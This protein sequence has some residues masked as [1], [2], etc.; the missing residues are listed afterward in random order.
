VGENALYGDATANRL[1]GH[2]GDDT[3]VGRGGDDTLLGGGGSDDFLYDLG[4]GV[5]IVVEIAGES[6][7]DR[8]VFGAG[9][10]QGDVTYQFGADQSE[11]L[12]SLAGGGSI[13]LEQQFVGDAAGVDSIHFADGFSIDTLDIFDELT[14][15]APVV[16]QGIADL[17]VDEDTA[18]D[19]TVPVDAFADANVRNQLT[20][21]AQL[22]G[23]L[24]LPAWLLF[25]GLSFTGTPL[26]DDVGAFDIEVTAT[27]DFGQSVTT[28][29]SLT[30]A[31]V[32][33]SPT[34]GETL[35]ATQ[36][37]S[38]GNSFNY[39]VP[40]AAF[41]DVDAGDLLTLTATLADGSP[42]PT[43]LQFDGSQFT[44]MPDAS[45][46]GILSLVVA[47]T[48]LAGESVSQNLQINVIPGGGLTALFGNENDD[49]LTGG[50]TAEFVVGG[51][52]DDTLA[53]GGSSDIYFY[54]LGDGNDLVRNAVGRGIDDLDLLS[55][56][57]GL[58]VSDVTLAQSGDDLLVSIA[59]GGQI[60]V[61]DFYH[62]GQLAQLQWTDGTTLSYNEIVVQTIGGTTGDD[63]IVRGDGH[64]VLGG[65][66]GNDT[67]SAGTG[68]D[69]VIGGAGD[70]YLQGEWH[71]DAYVYNLGDG[72]DTIYEYSSSTSFS[73]HLGDK[74]VLGPGIAP[75]EIIVT[76]NND[77]LDDVTI[78]FQGVVGSIFLNEQ[79]AGTNYGLETIEFADGTVW[80]PSDL[81]HVGYAQAMTSGD[82]RIFG[83]QTNDSINGAEGNDSLYGRLGADV[84]T[85]GA[86]D[87]YLDGNWHGDTYVYNL[88]DGHDTIYEYSSHTIHS[89]HLG[90]KLVLGPGSRRRTSSSP[91]MPATGRT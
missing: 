59:G 32:N 55:F 10:A 67:I 68:N 44:G 5:D 76:R 70:D 36:E 2:L 84:L 20:Y 66:G 9:I 24:P 22:A 23:G 40:A 90:D 75:S 46:V 37:A 7:G 88:G 29:F 69:I 61:Q 48:D 31:N 81:A 27:D 34:V 14:N 6:A 78:T 71:G 79:Y 87:D 12:V 13:T 54:N 16:D 74:L 35:P 60:L 80:T 86:G 15:V 89:R 73:R 3:L 18:L 26:N 33:D 42:L 8:L 72:D 91:A 82:D 19:F 4:D 65:G 57:S 45:D 50:A 28:Q 43:W 77:D 64:H 63:N 83:I 53:A 51:A 1:D 39:T 47:A 30:V 56:G 38:T 25:D 58:A 52:G 85:G 62:F 49:S 21:T 17:E 41:E 11:L